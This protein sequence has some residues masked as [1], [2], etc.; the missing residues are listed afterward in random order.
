MSIYYGSNNFYRPLK[1]VVKLYVGRDIFVET[2]YGLNGPG[3]ESRRGGD[4]S[5]PVQTGLGV[6]PAQYI[7]YRIFPEGKAAGAWRWPP[8][9]SSA[10]VKKEKSYTSSQ[11]PAIRGLLW[12]DLYLYLYLHG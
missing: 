4:I 1:S 5:A 6:H 10:E 7:G 11:P 9:P 2:R 12:G 8:T 3:I